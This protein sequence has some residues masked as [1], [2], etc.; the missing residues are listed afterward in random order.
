MIE[1]AKMAPRVARRSF[2][3]PVRTHVLTCLDGLMIADAL[4][5]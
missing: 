4:I 1:K 2:Q 5:D 3:L